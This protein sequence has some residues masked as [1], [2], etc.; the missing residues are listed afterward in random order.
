MYISTK[1]KKIKITDQQ[2]YDVNMLSKLLVHS[3]H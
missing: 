2:Y 1:K 3:I